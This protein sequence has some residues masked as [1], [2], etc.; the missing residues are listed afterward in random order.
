MNEIQ[1][2]LKHRQ[3]RLGI[4][5]RTATAIHRIVYNPQWWYIKLIAKIGKSKLFAD[6]KTSLTIREVISSPEGSNITAY[7]D[8][9]DTGFYTDTAGTYEL[10]YTFDSTG[11]YM[12][13]LPSGVSVVRF[14]YSRYVN[15]DY[16]NREHDNYAYLW[17]VTADIPISVFIPSA[18]P[19]KGRYGISGG[20]PSPLVLTQLSASRKNLTVYVPT[21]SI[22][23]YISKALTSNYAE[24]L[25]L[26][27]DGRLKECT[28]SSFDADKTDIDLLDI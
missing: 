27:N 4:G 15:P 23:N 16:D 14:P 8:G 3:N 19:P 17:D 7:K 5:S 25:T 13:Y 9:T 24:W 28:F 10:Y 6:L 22:N 2:I 18:I 26:Y 11:S 1:Q 21:G 20:Y 12:G